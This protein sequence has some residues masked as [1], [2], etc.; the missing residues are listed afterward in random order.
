[1]TL[2]FRW[3]YSMVLFCVVPGKIGHAGFSVEQYASE[4]VPVVVRVDN[5]KLIIP[6]AFSPNGDGINDTWNIQNI[7]A[8][9]HAE[10]SV[11]TRF[12]QKVYQSTTAERPFDGRFSGKDLP[13]DVYYYII[14][15]RN[16]TPLIKGHI[17][18]L[19]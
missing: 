14:D 9:P 18:L 17:S 12:G 11:Y 2:L 3:L 13:V 10:I 5:S 19:R 15:L 6:N 1:M 16:G 8:Y 7:T 4:R